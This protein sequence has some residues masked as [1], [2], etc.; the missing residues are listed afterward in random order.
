MNKDKESILSEEVKKWQI[1][2]AA[3]NF[4]IFI[5]SSI[6][7]YLIGDIVWNLVFVG[8]LQAQPMSVIHMLIMVFIFQFFLSILKLRIR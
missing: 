5:I 3:A 1:V 8:Y 6:F 2:L 7:F 4:I